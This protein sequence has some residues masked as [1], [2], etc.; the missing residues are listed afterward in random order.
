MATDRS[1]ELQRRAEGRIP[2]GVDSPVRSMRAVGG[3]PRWIA[4][5]QGAWMTDV[6]GNR[7][8]DFIASWGAL[9]GG[10][11]AESIIAAINAA[12]RRGTSFGASSPGELDLAERIH[13]RMPWVELLRFVNSGTEATMSAVRVAR[14]FTGRNI[15]I[16]FAGGYHGHADVFL[17]QAG[18]GVATLGLASSAGV[19][20]AAVS[21]TL[22]VEFNDPGAVEAALQRHPNQV[23]C[24][25]VE[26]VAGNMGCVPP[27][28]GFLGE[29]RRLTRQHGALLIFDEVMTGFRVAPGGAAELYGVTPDLVTLGK[30]IGGGL[31]VGAFGGRSDIMR[32]LAPL[33][34]VYQAGT[35]SGNPLAMAAGLA[36][37]DAATAD[38]YPVLEQWGAQLAATLRQALPHCQVQR[39]GS[40]LTVFFCNHAVR[41]F[42]DAQRC[43]VA[44][45]ARFHAR[46][47]AAGVMWPPSQFEAAFFGTAHGVAELEIFAKNLPA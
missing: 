40:M 5:A 8:L 35:L 24:V 47:L 33:G 28:P 36:A 39:V 30:I 9:L 37:L 31:P 2:G 14:G 46:L 17:A 25:I 23:A 12:A 11:A 15:I 45:F 34:P 16:K 27:E 29:L 42:S 20:A 10:H 41:N 1:S 6:D 44:A 43:D 13:A 38:V 7:Y 32:V 22:T 4:S 3:A 18:S 26:P 21:D 19:P